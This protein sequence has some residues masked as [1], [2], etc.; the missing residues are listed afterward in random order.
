MSDVEA[1]IRDN[2]ANCIACYTQDESTLIGLPR[3]Y[4]TPCANTEKLFQ[5]M[6]YWDS[7]FISLGLY[8]HGLASAAKDM[9]E[10]CLYC[11]ERFGF[12]PNGN[13]TYY[14]TR[15]QPPYLSRMVRMAYEESKD[16][17]WLKRC[18]LCLEKELSFWTSRP[19]A[20]NTGLSRY[21]DSGVGN[22]EAAAN[23]AAEAESGWDYTPRFGSRVLEINPLDLNSNLYMYETDLAFIAGELGLEDKRMSYL[24]RAKKRCDTINVLC[25]NSEKKFYFDFNFQ[26][27][28]QMHYRT[29]AA[30]HPLFAG[31]A[32]QRQAAAICEN[33]KNFEYDGGLSVCVEN[34]GQMDKQWNWPNGWAPLHWIA[35]A[36]LW[37]YGYKQEA[38]RISEKFCSLVEKVYCQTGRIWEKYNV[39]ECNI[40]TV[41]ERYAM[42]PMLGWTA[43]V[44]VAFR[45]EYYKNI[46]WCVPPL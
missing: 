27:G 4:I 11:I 32:Q 6:Y 15:S 13:R 40:H 22:D 16:I 12:V 24:N 42:P 1:Y 19:K 33:I 43:G 30:F 37:R 41:D 3:P 29:L 14:L 21:F 36:G 31:A 7:Y 28:R 46:H 25:W 5:E 34:Y 9:V 8:C 17:E 2:W 18:F 44:Y 45:K 20:T 38:Q 23:S 39:V 26:T 35:V 10:N